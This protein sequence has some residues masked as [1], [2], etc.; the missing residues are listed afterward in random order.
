MSPT[1]EPREV[2]KPFIRQWLL[3]TFALFARSPIRFGI[4]IALL[5]WLDTSA[6]RLA[7]GYVVEKP[8]IDRVGMVVLPVLW[9]FIS[10][11]RG[12]GRREPD[13]DSVGRT[14]TEASM[15]KRSRHRSNPGRLDLDYRLGISGI[16]AL[17][18]PQKPRPYLQHPGQ[19][20]DSLATN[21]VLIFVFVGL[22]YF[23]LL[24][25]VPDLSSADARNLSKRASD[26]NGWM[27]IVLFIGALAIGADALASVVPAYG[28][29]TAA[30]LVFMGAL[31][32]V[33]YR[34]IFER[35]SGNLPQAASPQRVP[36]NRSPASPR[37]GRM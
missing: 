11:M 8:W 12:C 16:G 14:R 7:E 29:T 30:F 37:P 22:C 3:T 34:D 23:P 5:G 2:D 9:I 28:M 36:Y 1:L 13:M 21:V 17:L 4:V 15:G 33:A 32:Y 24:V 6:I 10:T 31:S 18:A 25:L 26:I 19:F 27:V 35:R 20:L